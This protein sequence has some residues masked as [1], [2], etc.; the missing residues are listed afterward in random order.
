MG[1]GR[2]ANTKEEWEY[3]LGELLD[4]IMRKDDALVNY[5]TVRDQFSMEQ[6]GKD[7]DDVMTRILAL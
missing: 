6:R 4:P 3:H 1:V 7:W 5:E 2:I